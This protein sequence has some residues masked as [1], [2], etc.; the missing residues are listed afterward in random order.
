MLYTIDRVQYSNVKKQFYFF[1]FMEVTNVDALLD[2]NGKILPL[3][4]F[5][6]SLNGMVDSV[7]IEKINFLLEKPQVIKYFIFYQRGKNRYIVL[8][9]DPLSNRVRGKAWDF[10]KLQGWFKKINNID[11]K[12]NSKGLGC[13]RDNN[14]DHY[15]TELLQHIYNDNQFQDDNGLELTKRLLGG[16]TTKGFDLD[17]FQYIQSTEEYIIFEFLK[18]ENS[19]INNIE[20]HPMRYSWTGKRYDNKQ[21]FI[22]LWNIKQHLNSRLI[23]VNYSDN[24]SEKV[25]LIEVLDLD[26]NK[27]ITAENK[28]VM[29]K[30]VFQG[31]LYDMRDYKSNDNDYFSDFKCVHYEAEFFKDFDNNKQFY[32]AEFSSIYI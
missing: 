18:R 7:E 20:A 24:P 11:G 25:S 22:S 32:G 1:E 10:N 31:W 3:K 12:S 15:V 23:L 8:E 29:S 27:G 6:S 5:L 16:D 19:Y 28:Y 2:A 17:L 30:N 21:K 14:E 26:I 9:L 4:T 13:V